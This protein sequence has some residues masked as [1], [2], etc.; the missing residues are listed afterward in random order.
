MKKII[1][2]FVLIVSMLSIM[3]CKEKL[4]QELDAG[5]LRSA[6]GKVIAVG[7]R[8][9]TLESSPEKTVPLSNVTD[10]EKWRGKAE[11]FL[12]ERQKVVVIYKTKSTDT[13][14]GFTTTIETMETALCGQ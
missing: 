4:P 1:S 11:N 8:Y 7:P 10:I 6:T 9:I 2:L 14:G 3:G 12:R 5:T 13:S